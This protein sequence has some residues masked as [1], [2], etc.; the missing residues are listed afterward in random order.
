DRRGNAEHLFWPHE[1]GDV[2]GQVGCLALVAAEEQLETDRA[3]GAIRGDIT[4]ILGPGVDWRLHPPGK[5]GV[6]LAWKIGQFT[7]ANDHG[8]DV[9]RQFPRVDDLFS[10]DATPGVGGD[11]AYVIVARLA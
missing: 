1:H 11:V 8:L 5:G 2:P 6:E 4:E 9:P 10:I 3:I 7:V